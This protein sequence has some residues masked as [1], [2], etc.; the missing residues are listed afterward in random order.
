[1]SS[2]TYKEDIIKEM[3]LELNIPESE[4]KEIIDLN[5]KYIK[6]SVLETDC[7][8]INLPNLCKIRLNYRLALDS[9][10]VGANNIKRVISLK[11]KIELLKAQKK[12][13]NNFNLMSFNKP[14]YERLWRKAKRIK[15]N[16][17]VYRKM[18]QM[19]RELEEETNKI[20][21]KIT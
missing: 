18:Y 17:Y 19:I 9:A 2:I 16:R 15:Y 1:M 3:S 21:E 6:K 12:D 5:T 7:L 13:K 4:L 11:R 14:L 8:L 20:I 10:T